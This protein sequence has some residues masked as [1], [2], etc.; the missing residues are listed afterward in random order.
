MRI[1]RRNATT[2]SDQGIFEIAAP[3]AKKGNAEGAGLSFIVPNG[4]GGTVLNLHFDLANRQAFGD[5]NL[6]ALVR[7][8]IRC[9]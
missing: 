9:R 2:D 1:V 3:V 6:A 7:T 8:P 5:L 4:P